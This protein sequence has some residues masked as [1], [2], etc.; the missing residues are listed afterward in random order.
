[1]TWIACSSSYIEKS[2]HELSAAPD[3]RLRRS[4]LRSLLTLLSV[5]LYTQGLRSQIFAWSLKKKHGNPLFPP[6]E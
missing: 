6:L 1:M 4:F 3:L 5:W 2:L